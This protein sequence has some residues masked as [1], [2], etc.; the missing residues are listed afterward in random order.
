MPDPFLFDINNK[1]NEHKMQVVGCLLENEERGIIF[2]VIEKIRCY[3]NK[4]QMFD[5][6]QLYARKK[7]ATPWGQKL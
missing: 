3:F 1:H 4:Y 5:F 6:D 7:Y 2:R